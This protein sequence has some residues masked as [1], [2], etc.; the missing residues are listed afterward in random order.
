VMVRRMAA[1]LQE[2]LRERKT[3]R[4]RCSRLHDSN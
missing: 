1:K 2:P 4:E 3:A